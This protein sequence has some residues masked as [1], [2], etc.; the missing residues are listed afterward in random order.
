MIPTHQIAA[1]L[2]VPA[3]RLTVF[4][5]G[6]PDLTARAGGSAGGMVWSKEA[7]AVVIAAFIRERKVPATSPARK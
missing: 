1:A 7:A 2:G 6:R 5:D 4:L 3:D